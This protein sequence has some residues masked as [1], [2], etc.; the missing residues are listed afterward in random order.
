MKRAFENSLKENF[1]DISLGKKS[2]KNPLKSKVLVTGASGFIGS[3]LVE[4]LVKEEYEVRALV[5][6]N[7]NVKRK[8]AME[9][10]EKLNVEIFE[11]DLL[12][13][14]SMK[15]AVK[16]V[17][18]VFHLAAI[19]RPMEI[20]S[21]LY[22][23]VNENGTD[24]LFGACENEGTRKIVMMSSVS[25]VG[26]SLN[27]NPVNEMTSCEPVDIYGWSKLAQEKVAFNYIEKGLDIVLLRP[28]MVFG[29]RDLEMLR[30]FKLINMR[31][32]PI[33]SKNKCFE[34]LYV[35]NLVSACLL[36]LEKGKIGEIY[37]VSN[38]E[39][40]SINQLIESISRAENRNVFPIFL[41]RI[42]F[43]YLG[44]I[45]EL[46]AKLIRIHPPFKHDTVDWMT[47]P[48]WYSDVTKIKKLG[49]IAEIDLNEGV[50]RTAEYYVQKGLLK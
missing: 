32:F 42:A 3:H 43:R 10:L 15:E 28:P 38:G 4:R 23:E 13:R 2:K 20:P 5:R 41:P 39:H 25:A 22:F 35:E 48:F 46:F 24:N 17:E 9:L 14:N 12:D 27:G 19:A 21:E 31:I 26:P 18:V 44:H 30:L 29:P 1:S 37:H 49:Y 6:E 34:F 45:V 8:D 50:R 7:D 11:G 16:N 40:Y 47:K 33:R 36:A